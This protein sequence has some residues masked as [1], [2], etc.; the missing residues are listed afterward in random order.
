MLRTLT[1]L[2]AVVAA[3]LVTLSP[4][5]AQK[6]ADTLRWP[7]PEAQFAMDVYSIQVRGNFSQA[8]AP[9]V[10][11]TLLDFDPSTGE[12]IGHIAKAWKQVDDTNYEFELRDDVTFHDGEKLTA[13]DVVYTLNY[14]IDPKTNLRFKST[15][16][17]VK[18]AEK[19]GP[20]KL[21]I[22]AKYPVPGGLMFMAYGWPIYPKHIHEALAD[23]ELFGTHP[24]GT[25][26]YRVTKMDKNAGVYAEKFPGYIATRV[27][28]AASIAHVIS[29]PIPDSGTQAAALLAGKVDVVEDLPIEQVEALVKSGRFET[30]VSPPGLGYNFLGFPSLGAKRVKALGD[31]RV[32]LAIVKAI[33]RKALVDITFGKSG[34]AAAPQEALCIKEELGC[35]YSRPMPD[36]DPAGAKKL[37]AEAGY[38]DGFDMVIS[39]FSTTV[40]EATA[41]SGMLHNIGIRATVAPHPVPL[42]RQMLAQGKIDMSIYGWTDVMFDVAPHIDRH[43]LTE[44]FDDT[45]LVQLAKATLTITDDA[46]RRKA[47]AKVFDY[48]VEKSYALPMVPNRPIYTHTKDLKITLP[49]E[50]RLIYVNPHDFAWK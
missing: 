24:V 39:C 38:A 13:D 3:S 40:A 7:L 47:A 43:F 37:L 32:R 15:W 12:F 35:G 36:F 33:D 1:A 9:S 27:K 18:S 42:R 10:Y 28:H 41:I 11:D 29:E 45:H 2:G 21:R 17:W 49:P 46:E 30:T 22:T 48:A 4:A 14:I 26:P 20:Y 34:V 44:E 50:R 6:S 16:E 25:G 31:E 8:W 19:L 5:F 23:K